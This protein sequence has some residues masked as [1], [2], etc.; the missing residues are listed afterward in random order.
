MHGP[1]SGSP[2]SVA[3]PAHH[4]FLDRFVTGHGLTTVFQPIVDLRARRVA[5]FE[6]LSRF[7]L[8]D[9]PSLSPDRW[10]QL[11]TDHGVGADLEAAAIRRALSHRRTL[12]ANCFLSVNVDPIHLASEPVADAFRDAGALGGVVVELTEHHAWEFDE[13]DR[14][15]AALR[16]AGALIAI[17][18]AGAGH[19]GLRQMLLLRPSILKLDRSMV[20]GI[21][22]DES[23]VA[24]A[25]MIGVLANRLDAWLLAEGIETAAEACRLDDLEVP[26]AQGWFFGRPAAPWA[27]LAP[28]ALGALGE[29]TI[30]AR[31]TLHRLV[32]AV[33]PVPADDRDPLRWIDHTDLYRAVVDADQRPIGL[34]SCVGRLDDGRV[35]PSLVANVHTAPREL[36]QRWS[37]STDHPESPVMVT[38]DAGR[39]LGLVTLRRL[40]QFLAGNG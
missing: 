28:D 40:M 35:R 33:A 10:F 22:R 36:A 5:G 20:A 9:A 14:S 7:D 31:P 18:D 13:I 32:D 6:A 2:P 3:A 24:V 37:T 34:I 38:D 1:A 26:L 39:Y 12:P 11:A 25:E 30:Q 17:D 19:S 27:E 15:V 4:H 8:D 21:D 29:P 23:K 16:D